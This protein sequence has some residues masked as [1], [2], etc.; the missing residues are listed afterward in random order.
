MKAVHFGGGNIGRGFIGEVLSQNGFDIIF[1]DVNTEIINALN[2]FGSYKIEL[3]AAGK[4]QITVKNR[5]LLLS[6]FFTAAYCSAVLSQFPQPAF[7]C[8]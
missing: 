7:L 6:L 8:T 2:T 4:E 1:V 3:A 5:N